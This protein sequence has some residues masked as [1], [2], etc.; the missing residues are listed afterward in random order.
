MRRTVVFLALLFPGSLFG[1]SPTHPLDG[2]SLAEHWVAYETLRDS[3]RITDGAQFLYLGLNEPPKA[4]VLTWERGQPFRREA[5]LQIVDEGVGYGAVVDLVG[6]SV[7]EFEKITDRQYMSAPSDFQAAQAALE[8][9]DMRAGLERQGITDFKMIECFPQSMGYFDRPEE[10]NRRL[11]RVTCWNRLGSL[12]GWGAPITNLV[13][14]VDLETSEVVRVVDYGPTPPA[15]LMGEH[16]VEALDEPRAK[17]PPI[18]VSQPMGVGYDVEG[19]E[20]SWDSWRFHFRIDPRRGIVLSRVRYDD[21]GT[22]RSVLYQASLSEIFVPYQ[23]P[24]E[25]WNH[26][27]YY[28]LGT[29]PSDFGGIA[30]T[31]DPGQ[32]CP[33]NARYF[34]TFIVQPDGSPTQ[35][36]RV[37]CLYERPGAEPAWRHSRGDFVESRA[38]RDLVLRM[39]MGAENYD[40]LFDWVFKPDGSIRVLLTPLRSRTTGITVLLTT[41]M[42]ASWPPTWWRSTTATSSTSALISTSMAPP[43]AWP[44]T[45]W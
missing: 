30:S 14:I 44:W 23:D 41:V 7:I 5:T 38:R 12:T 6:R 11:G 9:P 8:H 43:T 39:I 29:Y 13:A 34:D 33:S 18:V 36:A 45:G 19:T 15:S 25:P 32:D 24:N 4:E 3:G 10:Q 42:V 20:V 27:A 2:L 16:H 1:Q 21:D 28:D 22:E 26:Q 17:L 40:Y 35:R 37:A 31:L